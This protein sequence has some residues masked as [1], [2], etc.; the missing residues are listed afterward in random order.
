MKLSHLFISSILICLL[1]VACKNKTDKQKTRPVP[2]T[3]NQGIK[4]TKPSL[5]ELDSIKSLK[6]KKS[7][8]L[9]TLKPGVAVLDESV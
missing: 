5:Q 9:D 2:S 3:E 6:K 8:R 4:K 1:A 7:K